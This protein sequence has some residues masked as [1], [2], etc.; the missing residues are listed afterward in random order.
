[1]SNHLKWRKILATILSTLFLSASLAYN[2]TTVS[3]ANKPIVNQGTPDDSAVEQA[4]PGQLILIDAGH[5]GI[6]GGTSFENILEKDI[7]LDIAKRLYLLLRSQ[8]Y[9]AVLNRTGDYA[10]SEDNHWSRTRSRHM[11]DLAQRQ[12]LSD[13]IEPTVVVSLHVNWGKN[14]SKGGPLVLHQDEG[15]SVLLA[16]TIQNAL[17]QYYGTKTLPIVGKPFYLL[18]QNKVPSVIVEM[19]YIS[20]EKDRL[21]MTKPSGKKELAQCIASGLSAYLML[22]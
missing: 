21:N 16:Y 12:E 7:N 1:M 6:D 22:Q 13:E 3:A 14:K 20:N 17:N 19:G 18:N 2:M 11:R 4:F 8:G 10:L 15:R 5:G 9:D